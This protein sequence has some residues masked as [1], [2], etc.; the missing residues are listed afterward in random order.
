MLLFLPL[1]CAAA[2]EA[3]AQQAPHVDPA[4]RALLRPA[5]IEALQ[6]AP[7]PLPA[8]APEQHVP[9]LGVAVRKA[10]LFAMPRVSVFARIRSE[11][12]VSELRAAGAIV[13]SRTGG[14]LTAEVPVDKLN[15]LLAS[16][17]FEA[18][19][20][21]H[22]VTLGNDTSMKL[23]RADYV[24][25]AS[26]ASWAGTAGR[27]VVVGV[28][29]TGLDFTHDDF[30]AADGATRVLELWDQT[31][32]TGGA[33]PDGFTYGRLCTRAAIAQ[34]LA[35][36]SDRTACPE[37]DSHGHGTHVSGSA[38][39]DGSA[40]GAGSVAFTYAGV[41]PLA[42]LM[43]VKGGDGT[44]SET[45]IIDG[46]V[47]L[48]REARRLNRPMVVNL[49]MGTQAGPHDGTRLYE[50]LIDS[51]SRPGFVVV[52]A[53]GNGGY[54]G[55]DFKPDGSAPLRNPAYSHGSGPAGQPRDFAI[56]I[57]PYSADQGKCNDYVDLSLWY[58]APDMLDISIVR[59]DGV[60]VT[61][62]FGQLRETEDATGNVRIDNGTGG[63]RSA[64]NSYQAEI[65]IDDCGATGAAP[66]SG[67]WT[68]RVL[69]RSSGSG[70]N[71]HFWM[72]A[73]SL[74]SGAFAVGRD[75]FDNH[76]VVNSPG[77]ARR[78]IAVGAFASK[79]CWKS[80]AKPDGAV[81]FETREAI[82]DL[83]RFSAGGPAR[84]DRLKPEIT[85]P[86]LAI[87]S[88]L[89]RNA[90]PPANRVL[91]DGVHWMNQGTSMAT[92]EVTGAVALM[93]EVDPRL[94]PED[95]KSILA[96]TSGQDEFTTR[97]YD[98]SADARP[99]YW[100]GYGKLDVCGA[101][102]A[103]AA[104]SGSTHAGI[105]ITPVADTIPLNA[106]SRVYTCSP[107]AASVTFASTDPAVAT[108]DADGTVHA[109]AMGSALVIARAGTSADTAHITIADAG[110]L[111]ASVHS[112]APA[113][114]TLGRRGTR[115]GLLNTVLY[116]DGFEG[117]R[118]T[119][120]S[121]RVTGA[122]PEATVE[123]IDDA[124][125]NGVAESS[126]RLLAARLLPLGDG[127]VQVDLAIDS[128]T[129]ARHDSVNVLMAIELSGRA[130]NGSAF[131]A[132]LVPAETRTSNL[133][134]QATNR[135]GAVTGPLASAPATTTLLTGAQAFTLSE[136]PVRSGRVVLNFAQ[137][138][139]TAG[140]YTLGGRLVADLEKRLS[141]NTATWDLSNDSGDRVASGVYLIVL[142]VGGSVV[143]QRLFVIAS[144]AQ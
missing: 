52:A 112:V 127:P 100:W 16:P 26:G 60:A 86:G 65:R 110:R 98:A 75:N 19:E 111:R 27:G 72:Y 128:L 108:V 25:R 106:T 5:A 120:L 36:P 50:M 7:V 119:Q 121:Y 28:Y 113:A 101:V 37:T 4:L 62:P 125:R 82:G 109:R 42:D 22:V 141:G 63:V 38:A 115:L 136:N 94:T 30:R 133:R 12:A 107:P 55:N 139:S 48:E 40:V 67:M 57:R 88:A 74:G 64:N 41:A 35:N 14:V 6:R 126:E 102:A 3:R 43:V 18:F 49:S 1:V 130:P 89:S 44:F 134:S 20:A 24:R 140:I 45:N 77:N 78:A 105:V 76:Y 87:A 9:T 135:I 129:V 53:A 104:L 58:Y 96:R 79:L 29:D 95:V 131:T 21:A 32:A 99:A 118:V 80:P 73:Q 91:A 114:A 59:P 39:G 69:P 132:E 81:C 47:W 116:A 93:L 122:D 90:A 137:R 84:D 68:L 11:A 34:V 85:A 143:R 56:E 2:G 92:P 61:A 117:I 15:A 66:A 71:Y 83:A 124:N 142:N 123:L 31:D 10:S 23:T 54:N 33:P 103:A 51:I 46:L 138:P 13:G 70:R 144:G 8:R 17:N 97:I